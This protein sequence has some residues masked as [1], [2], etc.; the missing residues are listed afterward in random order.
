MFEIG[1]GSHQRLYKEEHTIVEHEWSF[2][3]HVRK[4]YHLSERHYQW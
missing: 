2:M 3:P 1:V 4:T